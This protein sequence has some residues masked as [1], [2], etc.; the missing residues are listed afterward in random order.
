MRSL[1]QP[2]Y[3][4]QHTRLFSHS[5]ELVRSTAG[6][7]AESVTN[8]DTFVHPKTGRVSHCYRINYRSMDRSLTNEEIDAL[9]E[10]VR[11]EASVQLGVELR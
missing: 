1:P 3:C 6:D 5:H 7:L 8:I 9:Q 4:I 2:P 11:V 10:T